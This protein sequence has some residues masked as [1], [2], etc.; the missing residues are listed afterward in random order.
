M[1]YFYA[2]LIPAGRGSQ[3]ALA[4]ALRIDTFLDQIKNDTFLIAAAR[5]S[6]RSPRRSKSILVVM[7]LMQ[8]Q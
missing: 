5:G 8:N 4:L 1:I 2:I 3:L 7:N 6:R